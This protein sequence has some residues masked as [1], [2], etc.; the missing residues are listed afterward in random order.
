MNHS[1][2]LPDVNDIA[3]WLDERCR[4]EQARLRNELAF[5]LGDRAHGGPSRDDLAAELK[6]RLAAI[7]ERLEVVCTPRAL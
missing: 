7:A 5:I 4:L 6:V 1:I 2:E 3:T